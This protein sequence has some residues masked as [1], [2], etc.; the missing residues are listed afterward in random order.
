M[1]AGSGAKECP[2]N[3]PKGG[4]LIIEGF[5]I[6]NFPHNLYLKLKKIEPRRRKERKEIKESQKTL[7]PL[8]FKKVWG[9]NFKRVY[10]PPKG[11]FLLVKKRDSSLEISVFLIFIST[12][13][14]LISYHNALL[15]LSQIFFA[16]C[17]YHWCSSL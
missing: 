11:D 9:R 12:R 16:T 1:H 14:W 5:F 10:T 13:A 7:P 3:P 4:V 6:K 2:L 17:G 8:R 15:I